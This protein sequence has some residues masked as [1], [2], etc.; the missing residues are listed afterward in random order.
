LWQS[1]DGNR[2]ETATFGRKWGQ[3]ERHTPRKLRFPHLVSP[4][5]CHSSRFLSTLGV[6]EVHHPPCDCHSSRFLSSRLRRGPRPAACPR[7]GL[8]MRSIRFDAVRATLSASNLIGRAAHHP[9]KGRKDHE[10]AFQTYTGRGHTTQS[11]ERRD[12]LLQSRH[13]M[14]D[15]CTLAPIVCMNLHLFQ[16]VSE[17]CE[18]SSFPNPFCYGWGMRPPVRP[19]RQ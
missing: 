18:F 13:P 1:A 7:L 17:V 6:L 11:G 14:A 2:R 3:N 16:L 12:N 19:Q 4:P 10:P 9:I 15:E 5:D 8:P